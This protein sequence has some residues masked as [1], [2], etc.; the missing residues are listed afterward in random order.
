MQK[1][2]TQILS[3]RPLSKE[4][5]DEAAMHNIIIDEISFIETKLIDDKKV[6]DTI[7]NYLQQNITAI[8]TSMNAVDAVVR[9]FKQPP[10]WK[11][12]CIDNTTK[13]LVADH[14]GKEYIS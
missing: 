10:E 8:F 13:N 14:F 3:T 4:L 2:K 11:I 9:H 1:N 7:N 6:S 12:Y 5:I